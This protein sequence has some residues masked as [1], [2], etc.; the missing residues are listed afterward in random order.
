MGPP[1]LNKTKN[2]KDAISADPK[3]EFLL[4]SST[5]HPSTIKALQTRQIT[6]LGS[7]SPPLVFNR[8][9]LISELKSKLCLLLQKRSQN[10]IIAF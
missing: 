9:L 5:I 6:K 8:K 4:H 10:A 3:Q 7:V 1:T 2:I